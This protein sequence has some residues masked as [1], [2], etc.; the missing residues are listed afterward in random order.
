MEDIM[1]KYFLERG[2][3]F[4]PLELI[5]ISYDMCTN[6]QILYLFTWICLLGFV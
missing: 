1:S 3:I 2:V 4:P 6:K 5:D